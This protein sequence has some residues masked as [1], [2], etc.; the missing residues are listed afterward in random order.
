MHN[1]FRLTIITTICLV[2]CIAVQAEW[3]L[4]NMVNKDAQG[5][6]TYQAKPM[7]EKFKNPISNADETAFQERARAIINAQGQLKVPAGNTYFEN[8]KRT[9]GYLMAQ[10]LAGR[11][12]AIKDLQF[13]DAQAKEWHQVTEG[14]DFYACFTIKHQTRKYF[15]FGDLLEPEYRAR[16]LRGAK[17]WT[18][19]DPMKRPH[20]TFKQP[21]QGWGPNEKNSWVDVRTTENL[22]LMRISSVYLFAE[23]AG[24]KDVVAKYKDEIRQYAK[25]LYR[26]GIANGI[27][28]T[29][30]VT[31]WDRCAICM[32]SPK[33][34][35]SDCSPRL[36][37][38][39]SSPR[40]L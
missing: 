6:V 10:I 16:M 27:L 35:K 8:E 7:L 9:Y 32:T 22:Y 12:A 17:S 33:M 31:R 11:T 38:I 21:G 24:N 4:E 3:K 30:T 28:K 26:I 18:S 40:V 36:A 37:S 39:G 29:I 14:I 1:L 19:V 20:P 2:Y 34:T 25:T 23:E 13:E 15:Y 5:R